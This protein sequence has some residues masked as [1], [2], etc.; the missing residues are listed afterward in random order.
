L[1]DETCVSIIKHGAAELLI[2]ILD[3][4][5]EKTDT[6]PLTMAAGAL[7]NLGLYT[8]NKLVLLQLGVLPRA[9]KLLESETPMVVYCG[10]GLIKSLLAGGGAEKLNGVPL[11]SV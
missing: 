5:E 1:L 2:A 8:P 6:R 9:C 4:P 7:K 10:I 3:E 11:A